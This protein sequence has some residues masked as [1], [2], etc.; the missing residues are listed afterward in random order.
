MN[1]TSRPRYVL[2]DAF[3]GLAACAV[4]LYHFTGGDLAPGLSQAFGQ[5]FLQAC[6]HGWVGVQVFFVLSGFVIAN[7]VGDRPVFFADVLRFALR[8]QVRLDPPYW[9]SL[10][11]AAAIPWVLL[12]IGFQGTPMPSARVIGAHMVY[13]QE[14]LRY[15]AIQPVY[16]TL[17]I[18]VQFYMVFIGALA[19][20]RFAP[21]ALVLWAVLA[22][23]IASVDA[24]MHWRFLHGWFMPHWY[25]FVLGAMTCWVTARRISLLTQLAF[26]SFLT[27]TAWRF[28]RLEPMVG[29]VTAAILTLAGRVHGLENWLSARWLQLLGRLSYGIYLLHPIAGAQARWHVGIKVNVGSALGAVTVTAAA[30]ALTIGLAWT[31]HRF[32]EE[33]AMRL[34]SKIRWRRDD[35]LET[36]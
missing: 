7:S 33:P 15:P 27:Y 3:R 34:A 14:I 30:V 18:E 2:I 25:L 1:A 32:V 6:K 17:A 16:W 28:H 31:M 5:L 13:L 36:A 4:M 8:R 23:G 29:V 26:L 9:V 11:L 10:A 20:L 12:H 22:S 35:S 21:Q 24:A 19:M